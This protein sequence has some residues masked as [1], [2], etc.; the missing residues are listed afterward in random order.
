MRTL[1]VLILLVLG[2]G[3]AK[4]PVSPEWLTVEPA[5]YPAER[6]LIGRGQGETAGLARD[7]ARADLAKVFEVA[8]RESSSDS[9][10]WLQGSVGEDGLQTSIS[11]DIHLQTSQIVNGVEIVQTWRSENGG[12]YHALAVLDR[13]QAGNRLRAEIAALDAE[14]ARNIARARNE[15][16][17]PEKISAAYNALY[18]QLQRHH[19]QKML[20]IVDGTGMGVPPKYALAEL[21]SDFETLLDRWRIGLAVGKDELGGT[22]DLLAGALGNA[23]IRHLADGTQAEY[24]LRADVD[25][26]KFTAGDGWHWVRGTLR[27]SLLETGSGNVIGSHQW[28]YKSSALQSAMAEVRA[29]DE[30][31]DLLAQDL[32][33]VLVE[34]GDVAETPRDRAFRANQ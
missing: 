5:E 34:L 29:R 3:C 14:T 31:A 13:L 24:L 23:G 30:L 21:K 7:R 19:P 10:Q 27:V 4:S 20:R 22:S 2:A 9:L 26:D 1:I 18:A 25:S 17:L 11:R 8:V 33:K 6:Y 32:L 16:A 12:D 28:P 15:E